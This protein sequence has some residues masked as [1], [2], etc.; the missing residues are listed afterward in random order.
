[1]NISEFSEIDCKNRAVNRRTRCD[2]NKRKRTSK[3]PSRAH[4]PAARVSFRCLEKFFETLLRISAVTGGVAIEVMR[5]KFSL[6]TR[7]GGAVR[8][9]RVPVPHA[10]IPQSRRFRQHP[11]IADS[12]VQSRSNW[13]SS[14]PLRLCPREYAEFLPLLWRG[15][16]DYR[17]D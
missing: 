2:E 9:G 6:T 11:P 16:Q 3:Q 12:G 17:P 5:G 15:G 14:E 10:L 8:T 13:R 1:M 4:P 7:I